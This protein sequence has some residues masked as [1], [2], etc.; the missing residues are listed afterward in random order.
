MYIFMYVY[1][2]THTPTAPMK[3]K[4][5]E[6]VDDA[7]P[8]HPAKTWGVGG[9]IEAASRRRSKLFL[10]RLTLSGTDLVGGGTD[11]APKQDHPERCKT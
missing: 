8:S 7:G 10:L 2:Y 9:S 6:Q 4:G 11:A 1:I 3:T 5:F